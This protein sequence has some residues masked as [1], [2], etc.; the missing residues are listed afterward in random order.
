MFL[1]TRPPLVQSAF[2][3][4]IQGFGLQSKDNDW[5]TE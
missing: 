3:T 1:L 5:I 4:E 2:N